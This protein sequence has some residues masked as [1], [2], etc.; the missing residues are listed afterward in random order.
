MSEAEA[1]ALFEMADFT[2]PSG[3]STQEAYDLLQGRAAE[4]RASP[5]DR[6]TSKE[7]AAAV[8]LTAV[9]TFVV[10]YVAKEGGGGRVRGGLGEPLVL[11]SCFPDQSAPLFK[12]YANTQTHALPNPPPLPFIHTS[13]RA[14]AY[15]YSCYLR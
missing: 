6:D 14:H 3:V 7:E 8:K 13:T 5:L 12:S 9:G 1:I 10:C 2:P 4:A 15:T 11:L